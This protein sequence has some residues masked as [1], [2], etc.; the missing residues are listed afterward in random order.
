MKSPRFLFLPLCLVLCQGLL[1]QQQTLTLRFQAQIGK[2]LFSCG[3][4]YKE[5]GR[6]KNVLTL[7][8]FR[9]YVS[10]VA[11]L[12]RSGK[13][14]PLALE[15]DGRWQYQNVA[16]LDFENKTGACVN[17]TPETRTMITGMIPKGEYQGLQFTVGLP[18]DLNHADSTLAPSP[19]NLTSLWWNWRDGYKFMRIEFTEPESAMQGMGMM[20]GMNHGG[21]N[22]F[23]IHLGSTGCEGNS[24]NQAPTRCSA[25]NTTKIIL[26]NFNPAQDIVIADLKKLVAGLNLRKPKSA[27][28]CMS[29]A[30]DEDC[31]MILRHLG[32]EGQIPQSFFRRQV[33]P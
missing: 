23:L 15:Q 16:L 31:K 25:P 24:D 12:D 5:L 10:D 20:A 4:N 11:L 3:E 8:D 13:A 2:K 19:L 18:F 30:G 21:S 29:E 6:S 27:P 33:T 26:K 14:T 1:A 17:G 9:F 32:L 28:G 7:S 22:G